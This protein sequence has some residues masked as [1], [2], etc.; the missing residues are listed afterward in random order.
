MKAAVLVGPGKSK[1]VEL[2]LPKIGPSDVLIRV[3]VCGICASELYTWRNGQGNA[4]LGHEVVGIIEDMGPCVEGFAVGDRVTGLIYEGFAQYTKANYRHIVKV[5]EGMEAI[6]AIGEPLSCLLSGVNRTPVDLNDTVAI[7]GTGFMGLG[8]LQFIKLKGP[9]KIIAIDVR[10]ESLENA[11][12]FG[13]HEA[14]FPWQVEEKYLVTEWGHIGRGVEVVV[15]ASGSQKALDLAGAMTA[16]HGVLSIVGFHQGGTR[17]VN[18]E[19]WNWKGITVINAH[20]RRNEVHIDCMKK[21]L[22]IIEQGRFNMKDMI[23]HQYGLD[24]ID[25]AYNSL[26]EKPPGFIKAVVRM[27]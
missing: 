7:I 22:S 3:E 15:E 17:N 9:K 18:M 26:M 10:Q 1:V 2:P 19:L 12:K 27:S 11:L 23:T 6:E 14:I 8:F 25:E 5:P 13:A 20:E 21:A 24:E 4:I 16:V